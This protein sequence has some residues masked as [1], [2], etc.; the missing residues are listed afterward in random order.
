MGQP[1]RAEVMPRKVL[2]EDAA[3][4]FRIISCAC[5]TSGV[6]VNPQY[7]NLTIKGSNLG[8]I[9]VGRKEDLLLEPIEDK[10][11]P[12]GYRLVGYNGVNYGSDKVELTEMAEL[13]SLRRIMT[14]RQAVSCHESYPHFVEMI[15]NGL[16][17]DISYTNIKYV[18]MRLLAKY[19]K[20]IKAMHLEVRFIGATSTW[21]IESSSDVQKIAARYE[22]PAQFEAAMDA[23]PY[24]VLMDVLDWS[25]GRSDKL[26]ARMLPQFMNSMERAE[27][28]SIAILKVTEQSG[29]T[30]MSASVLFEQFTALAP[31]AMPNLYKA[32]TESPRIHYDATRKLVSLSN[33]YNAEQFI[34][35]TLKGKI[36]HPHLLPMKWQEHI[37][38][39]GLS[40]TEEQ[41][42]ILEMACN[43]DA[44]MLTG[45]AGCVDCDTEFFTGAGWKRIADYA[46]GDKVLQYNEDGTATLVKPLAYI[47]QLCDELW[48][49]ETKYG[50][51]QTICDDHNIVYW[52]QKGF[53]HE[54]HIDEIIAKQAVAGKGW[55]G[56]FKTVFNYDGPGVDLT[57]EQ[58]RIMCAVICD[59]SFYSHSKPDNP[60]YHTCRFHIKKERKKERLLLLFT[61]AGISWKEVPSAA[62]GYTDLYIESPIRTKVFESWWYNCNHHQLEVI[63]DEIMFWDGSINMTK[64]G[65]IRQ[66]FSTTIKET[67]DFI[68]FAYSACGYRARIVINDRS[69]QGYFTCGKFYTRKSAEYSVIV[70]NR[71]FVGLCSDGRT[72]HKKTMPTKVKTKDGYKYCFTVPSHALVLRRNG[73]VFITGNCGKTSSVKALI[74]MLEDEGFTYTL[75]APTGIAAKR[76]RESTGREASTIHM[77]LATNEPIG[78]FLILDEVGMISVSL[79]AKL[80]EHITDDT[81]IIFIADPSQLA[82]ISCG[83]VVRDLLDSGVIPVA[84]LTKVFR[85]NSSGIITLSTDV[86]NG[87][88]EHLTDTYADYKFIPISTQAIKQIG[89]EYAALVSGNY[90]P[91]DVLILSPFNKGPVGSMAI[92]AAIQA[93]FNPN[94]MSGIAYK[95]DGIE[96]GF[97]VGDRVINKKNEYSMPLYDSDE[98][99][100][101]A[102]GDIGTVLVIDPD[103]YSMTVQFDC[104]VCHVDRAHIQHLLL[105]YCVSVHACQGSQA[106]AVMVVIDSSHGHMISR[107]LLYTAMTRAQERLVVIGDVVAIE[108]GLDIQEEMQRNTWLKEMMIC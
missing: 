33:T 19:I 23:N 49:F 61:R 66:R 35:D 82:S 2:F 38:A 29:N 74:T 73:N 104:G 81:K 18:G 37:N 76:L 24:E 89:E 68:Q 54:C 44:M 50:I 60:S 48:H 17:S 106:K 97:K 31:Q 56:T 99:A 6:P 103:E 16:E 12:Y 25:F 52:S 21:G 87:R 58:I 92:N 108:H 102:N 71:V 34:A 84:N 10:A 65:N 83:N 47:K 5:F 26:V 3:S 91:A 40:L 80:L 15:L 11:H 86:R 67:A 69:G 57:D 105:G 41:T 78:Q 13:Q 27:A 32:V 98:T 14:E 75:L 55:G 90:N 63:C 88:N 46:P 1:I 30:R 79:L 100:F 22:E 62:Q 9:Q 4:G 95:R 20:Q 94:P 70:T 72:N 107:N 28:A 77:A 85:Y 42:K 36:A 64:N 8:N 59:G 39:D 53:K 101:V 93:K 51:N 45:P 43:K 7:K 96:I